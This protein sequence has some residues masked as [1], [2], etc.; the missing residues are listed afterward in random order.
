LKAEKEGEQLM[1][2]QPTHS[3]PPESAVLPPPNLV[4]ESLG[5]VHLGRRIIRSLETLQELIAFTLI[6]LSVTVFKIG[7]SRSVV[8]PLIRRQIFQAGIRLLPLVSLVALITGFIVV[9]QMIS[10]FSMVGAGRYTGLVMV[11]AVFRELGPLMTAMMVLA[12]VGTSTVIDL[13]TKRALGEVEAMEALGIDSIHYLVVPRVL[14]LALSIVSLTI[15]FILISMVSAYFFVFL[16]DIPMKP[17]AF[18]NQITEALHISDFLV[19]ILKSCF[20]GGVIAV[21]TCYEGLARPIRLEQI[22]VAATRAV[23]KAI[24]L[25]G[26]LDAVFLLYW[27][28]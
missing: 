22:S 3:M 20:F 27:M 19:L 7:R 25:C 23:M 9:G 8:H 28:I 21:V 18:V 5:F 14:G 1:A 13:G 4:P 10:L 24:I 2:S 16:Q 6:T 26:L 17:Q 11:I 15:Y 12:R